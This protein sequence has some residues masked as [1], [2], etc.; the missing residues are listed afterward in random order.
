MVFHPTI[1]IAY[2]V[3]ET[4]SEVIVLHVDQGQLEIAQQVSTL[5]PE[6]TLDADVQA[7]CDILLT[8]DGKHLIATNRAMPVDKGDNS[9]VV[10]SI[11]DA[12]S[13]D[14]V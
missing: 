6:T 12:G 11:N 8:K 2:V 3:C 1:Q 4:S 5:N 14:P 7:A 10:F 9:I 13:L